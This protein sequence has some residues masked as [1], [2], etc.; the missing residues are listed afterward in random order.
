MDIKNNPKYIHETVLRDIVTMLTDLADDSFGVADITD[1]FKQ[2]KTS[3]KNIAKA[4]RD[5]TL[6][7]PVIVTEQI[8]VETASMIA[9]AIERKAVTM[10]Q[11][12]FSAI[13]ITN[14]EDAISYLKKFHTNLD[15]DGNLGID[16]VIGFA[17]SISA[18][19]S[20]G[21]EVNDQAAFQEAVKSF[22]KFRDYFLDESYGSSRPLSD[23]RVDMSHGMRVSKVK[24]ITEAPD[25]HVQPVLVPAG[26]SASKSVKSSDRYTSA[27]N[28]ADAEAKTQDI[29]RNQ[30][31][32]TDIKKANEL[33]PS[34]MV[35]N[36][37][38]K[39]NSGSNAIATSAVIGV[40]ARLQYVYSD[41]MLDRII[42][43]NDDKNGLFN[44]LKAT[45]GQISFWKDFIFAIDRAKLDSLST[46]SKGKSSPIW[47]LLEHRAIKS[48]IRRWTGTVNDASAITTLVISKE[49][50]DWLK[51]EEHIDIM[52]PNVVYSVMN[53]YNIMCFIVVDEALE[54]VHFLFDDGTTAYE[55]VSFSHLEREANDGQ[56]KKIINLLSKSR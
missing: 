17:N 24:S 1:N 56:Y 28:K 33:V 13:T 21:I 8:S 4:S 31:F 9:K 37:I 27:K 42:I 47:K 36:Y 26:S 7:F 46:S 55:T 14:A 48:R 54:K 6:T 53:A 3:Y 34:M 19:E 18:E 43:K 39:G 22:E 20:T 23:Y 32:V 16:D 12:L 2:S 50:A 30:T 25:I 41:D 52:R 15:T 49:E 40:K 5:L 44:F 45:T 38:S 51:K 35:I 11:M 10:L 29:L